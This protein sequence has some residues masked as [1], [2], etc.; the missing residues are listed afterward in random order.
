[1]R[2]RFEDGGISLLTVVTNGQ[3]GGAAE[4]VSKP[5]FRAIFSLSSAQWRRGPGRG[6]AFLLE[7][8]LSS[9]LSPLLRHGARKKMPSFETASATP[10][11]LGGTVQ[12]VLPKS[13]L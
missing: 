8:P 2:V 1:L 11:Y 9:I 3:W 6:G 10:P 7:I 13:R 12:G 5:E 4:A